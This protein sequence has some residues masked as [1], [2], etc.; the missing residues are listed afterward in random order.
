M[1]YRIKLFRGKFRPQAKVLL[2]WPIW[3][4][5]SDGGSFSW[6]RISDA[7]D[8]IKHDRRGRK[9]WCL[10]GEVVKEYVE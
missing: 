9:K 3:F 8:A 5:R 6:L 4:D 10:F 1:R 7:E 2:W